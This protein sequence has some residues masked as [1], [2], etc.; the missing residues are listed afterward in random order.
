[1]IE[2]LDA[3]AARD[4][5]RAVSTHVIAHVD[6]LTDADLAIGDG[7]HGIGMRRGF[8]GALERLAAAENGSVEASFKLVG[9]AILSQT[10]GAAGAVFGTMFRS[11]AKAF[12]GSDIMDAARIAAFLETALEFVQQ[13]GGVVPGQK[14]MVDALAPAALAARKSVPAGLQETLVAATAA[15]TQGLE[16][17]RNMI[18]TTGKA[19]SLGERSLGHVDPGAITVVLILTA[20]RDYCTKL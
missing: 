12:G 1:M 19:R 14:T 15:A 5:L 8:E 7:D 20:M 17:T 11:G 10:G 13:R 6:V 2:S 18:A 9:N 3:L 16:A 4:M